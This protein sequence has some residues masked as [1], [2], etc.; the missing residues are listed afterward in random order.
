[1]NTEL[2][3]GLIAGFVN[4]STDALTAYK[5]NI[6]SND[7][8]N[9]KKVLNE[10]ILN[11]KKCDEFWFCIAFLRMSGDVAPIDSSFEQKKIAGKSV[12]QLVFKIDHEV[13]YSL[14]KYL[15]NID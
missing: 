9:N 4:E 2:L 6:L 1:M 10:I 14:Y 5:P 15:T 8:L 13:D 11:L 7:Y 12:V 3:N